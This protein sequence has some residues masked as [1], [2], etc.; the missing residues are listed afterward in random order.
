MIDMPPLPDFL[1]AENRVPLTPEQEAE[2]AA[3]QRQHRSHRRER[4]RHRFDLPREMDATAWALLR[5]QEAD[6]AAKQ[7]ARLAAL[8]ERRQLERGRR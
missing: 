6:R 3:W 8:K 1:R 7:K 2:Y 4:K 5:Q